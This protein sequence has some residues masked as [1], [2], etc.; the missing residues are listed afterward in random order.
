[1]VF[2]LENFE[3]KDFPVFDQ[4]GDILKRGNLAI[5]MKKIKEEEKALEEKNCG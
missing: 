4:L 1:M 3:P 2:K 5:D